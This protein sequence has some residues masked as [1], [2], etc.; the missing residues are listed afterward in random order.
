MRILVFEYI[1]GGGMLGE[2]IPRSLAQEGELMLTV[3][4]RDLS[5]LPEVRTVALRDVR[6]PVSGRSY[7]GTEWIFLDR[8]DDLERR[9]D[10]QIECCDAVWPIAPETGGILERICR[11]VEAAGKA[12]L[13]SSGDG[14]G[15]AASKFAT[16]KRLE[17]KG[18][19]A[20]PT[21]ALNASTSLEFPLVVKPDDG[22]G[23]E[24][25]RIVET[26]DEWEA[27]TAEMDDPTGYVVQ[28]LVEGEPL[29]LS[30]LF[31]RGKA[32]L[33]SCNRQRIV[34]SRGGFSLRGCEVGAIRT[35]LAAYEA[36][37]D[38]LAEAM[39]ELWGYVGVD[40]LRCEQGLKVLEVNPRLT[41]SYAGLRQSL[42]VNPA[43]L[44]LDLWRSGTLPE[45]RPM[46]EKA[47]EIHLEPWDDG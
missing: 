7:S 27:W 45:V 37:A 18:V 47:I 3:L 40:V 20:I 32:R 30:A 6:L 39:P 1:T 43:A 26:G 28:P 17:K 36:L 38:R 5:R 24:G 44:V 35:G 46:A 41:T 11:R 15:L 23:C 29:S 2:T 12:L 4:L 14:V 9:L 34:R 33:L 10:D 42:G 31:C 21:F 16:V 8:K 22:V 19:P 25:A 13:A